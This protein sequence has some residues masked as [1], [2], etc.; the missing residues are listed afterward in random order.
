MGKAKAEPMLTHFLPWSLCLKVAG[1][2]H[3][4]ILPGV[5]LGC[6][7]QHAEMKKID[8]EKYRRR[9]LLEAFRNRDMPVFS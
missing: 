5:L 3:F 4:T 2:V 7:L 9:A 6:T 8:L 1:K